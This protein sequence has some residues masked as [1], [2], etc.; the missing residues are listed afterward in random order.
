[1]INV[2]IMLEIIYIEFLSGS[3]CALPK[4]EVP[5]SENAGS[6]GSRTISLGYNLAY[7]KHHSLNHGEGKA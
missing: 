7:P 1:M 4:L 5:Q 6:I 2:G 3:M